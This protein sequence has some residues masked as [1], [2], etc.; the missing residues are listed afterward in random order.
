MMAFQAGGPHAQDRGLEAVAYAWDQMSRIP[1]NASGKSRRVK[2]SRSHAEAVPHRSARHRP[3]ALAAARF[4][5]WNSYPGLF[6]DL[7]TGN[8]V[9][10]KPHPGA[11]LPLAITVE[12]V[13]GVLNEAGFD[14]N[15]V[16]LV[17]HEK[18]D[19]ISRTLATAAR[20]QTDRFHRQHQNGEWLEQN[21]HQA[22][23]FTEKAG[24]NQI[25]IDSTNDLK[26]MVRNIAF[27]LSLYSG[28]MC[29]APQNIYVP[30]SGIET[31]EGHL[32]FDQVADAIGE[33]IAK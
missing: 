22:H 7:A 9:I 2:T 16:T 28:Q 17:A 18:K 31:P 32:T 25:V 6:A 5:T 27:S 13:R 14:P 26:G 4:P 24:I 1:K 30:K 8:A 3:R 33:G 15:V 20:N 11:I 10:V 23:V 19:D 29:T 12:V 21:A